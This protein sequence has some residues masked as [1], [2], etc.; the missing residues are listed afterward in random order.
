MKIGHS[1]SFFT[2]LWFLASPLA[3][4]AQDAVR[5]HEVIR[6]GWISALTGPVSKYAAHQAAILAVD[7]IIA[8]AG[9]SGRTLELI[10]EDG[11]CNGASTAT[12]AQKLI[13]ID[14]VK[15]I[16]GGHCSAETLT[17][18]PIAERPRVMYSETGTATKTAT[19][20]GRNQWLLQT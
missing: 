9:I 11:M 18:A 7:D 16:L 5:I 1:L 19:A 6:I 14:H 3:S 20:T 13:N 8:A 10:M 4:S 17:L 2:F 12:A 15:Y